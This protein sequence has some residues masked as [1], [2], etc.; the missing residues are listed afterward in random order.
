MAYMKYFMLATAGAN[1]GIITYLNNQ[2]QHGL[3]TYESQIIASHPDIDKTRR[4][5]KVG[6]K[7]RLHA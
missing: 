1:Q 7:S 5:P 3:E 6:L 4:K 2:W